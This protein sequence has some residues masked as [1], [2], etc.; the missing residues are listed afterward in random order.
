MRLPVIILAFLVIATTSCSGNND[1]TSAN[2]LGAQQCS[3]PSSLND[4]GPGGCTAALALVS[5]TNSAGDTCG[6]LSSSMESCAVGACS[7]Y[8]GCRDQCG[9]NEYA[10]ACGSIG[11]SAQE[12]ANPPAGCTTKLATPAGIVYYC[13]PCQ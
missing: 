3:W 8:S 2:D 10:V 11:P 13:C 4:A 5:C 1:V 7:G 12:S 6:C 9:A